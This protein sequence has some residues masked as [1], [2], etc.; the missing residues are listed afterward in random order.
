M[1]KNFKMEFY[2]NGS[3]M[4]YFKSTELSNVDN[5]IEF[6]ADLERHHSYISMFFS[7]I[8]FTYSKYYDH[9]IQKSQL[10]V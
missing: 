2:K 10:H 3:H 5:P 8:M 4:V 1:D 6:F 7:E 9:L